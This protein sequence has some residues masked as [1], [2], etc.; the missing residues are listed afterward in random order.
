M[1]SFEREQRNHWTDEQRAEYYNNLN[2]LIERT[3]MNPIGTRCNIDVFSYE[4]N[5]YYDVGQ[6][7]FKSFFCH[8]LGFE[9]ENK[10]KQNIIRNYGSL[11]CN[12]GEFVFPRF[13][14][15]P[16]HLQLLYTSHTD[17]VKHF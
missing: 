11:C 17:N 6:C 4:T 14:D 13:L 5:V 9:D 2:N 10:R 3:A 8:A 15:I 16:P 7:S 12:R 1:S